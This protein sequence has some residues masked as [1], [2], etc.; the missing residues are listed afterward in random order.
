MRRKSACHPPA[1]LAGAR[2]GTHH[3]FDVAP[4]YGEKFHQALR[5]EATKRSCRMC[6]TFGC[7]KT[8]SSSTRPPASWRRLGSYP[9]EVIDELDE[10]GEFPLE[11]FRRTVMPIEHRSAHVFARRNTLGVS[12]L[13]AVS[14]ADMA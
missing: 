1:V 13:K 11:A 10:G 14:S 3:D 2:S 12:A 6:E 8:C 9:I 5:R 4:E 7:W